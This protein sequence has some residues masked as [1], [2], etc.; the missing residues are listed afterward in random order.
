MGEEREEPG[1][2]QRGAAG[3]QTQVAWTR[4]PLTLAT[5]PASKAPGDDSMGDRMLKT[6]SAGP[7]SVSPL[8]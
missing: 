5:C 1:E 3:P 2:P 4:K 7:P 8:F 6:S